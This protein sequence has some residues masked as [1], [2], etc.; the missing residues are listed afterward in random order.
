MEEAAEVREC[1]DVRTRAAA[2]QVELHRPSTIRLEQMAQTDSVLKSLSPLLNS[3]RLFGL[4][5]A[6]K[7]RVDCSTMTGQSD[8]R[9]GK[10]G[11]WNFARIYA[12]VVLVITWLNA[13]RYSSVFDGKETLGAV[14]FFKLVMIPTA[15]MNIALHTAYYVASLTGTLDRV[16]GQADCE[17]SPKY[18]RRTRVVTVVCWLLVAWTF[19]HYV[20]QLSVART[21]D[22]IPVGHQLSSTVPEP[23]VYVIKA[24][25]AVLQLQSIA[26]VLFPQAMKSTVL[27]LTLHHVTVHFNLLFSFAV[28]FDLVQYTIASW[29]VFFE[30]TCNV[31]ILYDRDDISDFPQAMNFMVMTV[32][33][34]QF[35]KLNED[36]G[37]CISVEGKFSGN[38]EQIRRCHQTISRR[39]QEADQVLMISNG[40]NFCCQVTT[41]ILV[42][43]SIIFYR[44]D[45]ISPDPESAIAYIAWL[46]FSV[47]SLALVAGQAMILNHTAS[48]H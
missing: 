14:L 24:V 4:Y 43:Y 3:M 15:L 19:F 12:T 26:A 33:Y 8:R 6:H 25:L 22:L 18:R 46:F 47:F 34:D 11:D 30:G 48:I 35:H 37:K 44:D 38:F 45:T 10:C 2:F 39:V 16:I 7:P 5:F 1:R 28:T 32:L 23:Y 9:V 40:A 42:L 13:F 17:L 29:P 27:S 20:Y 36:F 41:I 21:E 31:S